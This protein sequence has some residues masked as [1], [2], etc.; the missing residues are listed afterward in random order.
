MAKIKR[1]KQ[2]GDNYER[3]VA[4]HINNQI[5]GGT[6]VVTRAPLSGGGSHFVGKGG[7]ADLI[8]LPDIWPELKRNETLKIWDAIR[9]AQ[10]G[11]AG[12]RSPDMMAVITRRNK[13]KTG[14]SLVIM[15]MDDWLRLYRAYLASI[16]VKTHAP[17]ET[18]EPTHDQADLFDGPSQPDPGG[19][20]DGSDGFPWNA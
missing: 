16:G 20:A 3:E 8:G 2:K 5:F 19:R 15:K 10:R 12:R 17:I 18:K 1:V 14:D 9:Q 4:H 13:M 6:D 11:I 7:A